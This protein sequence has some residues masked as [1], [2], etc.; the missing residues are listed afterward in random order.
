ML[1]QAA[2]ITFIF[3]NSKNFFVLN[4]PIIFARLKIANPCPQFLKKQ[5]VI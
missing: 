2:K 3:T 1:Q 4:K 5:T